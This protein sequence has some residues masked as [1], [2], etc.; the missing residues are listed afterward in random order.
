M[1]RI[2]IFL[3]TVSRALAAL[4]SAETDTELSG[5]LSK[6]SV[7]QEKMEKVHSDQVRRMSDKC[8]NKKSNGNCH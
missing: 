1:I 3:F 2:K 7:V 6:L 4:S 8:L 5:A